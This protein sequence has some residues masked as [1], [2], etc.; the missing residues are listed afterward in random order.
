M[1]LSFPAP[2][3]AIKPTKGRLES[4]NVLRTQ[5]Y[6]GGARASGRSAAARGRPRAPPRRAAATGRGRARRR[7]EGVREAAAWAGKG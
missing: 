1:S 3:F 6:L 5:R 4:R 7:V 2:L